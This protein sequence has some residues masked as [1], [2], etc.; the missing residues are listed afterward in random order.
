MSKLAT[1]TR[2]ARFIY[3]TSGLMHLFRQGLAFL[4]QQLFEYETY[5]LYERPTENILKFSE[6]DFIPKVD[7]YNLKVIATREEADELEAQGF[8]L[9]AHVRNFD[10]RLGKGAI[11]FCIFT[12]TELINIGWIA[13]NEE[14]KRSLWQPPFRVDFNNAES[15]TG[16]AWTDPKY[17]NTGLMSYSLFKRLKFLNDLGIARDRAA[18]PKSNPSSVV[19]SSKFDSNVYAEGRYLR[20]LRFGF[21]RERPLP[22]P[23][24]DP[25]IDLGIAS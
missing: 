12:G 19:G 11:A 9:R 2:R 13:L 25:R 7:N 8:C 15:I 23:H 10:E 1:F 6:S 21:W 3:R 18:V 4:R 14:A 16:G 24:T 17:R 22:S 20:I 5:Y